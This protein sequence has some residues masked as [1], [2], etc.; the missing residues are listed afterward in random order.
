MS[1][2]YRVYADFK[3][4]MSVDNFTKFA[5][6]FSLFPEL[7]QKEKVFE[8]FYSFAVVYPILRDKQ[9]QKVASS[10][11]GKMFGLAS[12]QI[13]GT[14]QSSQ[15]NATELVENKFIDETI[16]CE[17]LIACAMELQSDGEVDSE[18]IEKVNEC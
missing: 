6:D 13:E 11:L 14:K 12:S 8:I 2:Y 9:R 15:L 18:P 4:Q 16:L 17:I 10:A 5:K 7:L 1:P 3:G